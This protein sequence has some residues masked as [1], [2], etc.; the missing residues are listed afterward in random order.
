VSWHR[1]QHCGWC[2][3]AC[4]QLHFPG[5]ESEFAA[6]LVHITRLR[7]KLSNATAAVRSLFGATESQV[8]GLGG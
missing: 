6:S 5:S 3:H 4:L 2:L 8:G 1:G 7:K